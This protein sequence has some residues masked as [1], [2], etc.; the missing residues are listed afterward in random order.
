MNE[1]WKNFFKTLGPGIL[2]A[3]TCVGVSHLVQSTRAGADYGFALVWVIV[4]A[5]IF[6]YPFFEFT[7]RYTSATGKSVLDGYYGMGKWILIAFGISTLFTMFIVTTAVTFVTAGLLSNLIPVFGFTTDIWV[8]I[9]LIISGMI[10]LVGKFSILDLLLKVIGTVLVI[11]TLAAFGSAYW[12]VEVTPA[13]DFVP[14]DPYDTVGILFIVALMGWMPTAVDMSVWT[15]LWTEARI[16]Q[17]NYHPKLKESLLDFNLGYIISAV[18]ALFFMGLGALVIFGTNTELS[19]SSPVFASQLINMYTNSIGSWSYLIIAVAAFS[20]MFSTSIT[21]MDGYG[22]TMA[23]ITKLLGNHGADDSRKAFLFWIIVLMIGTYIV[24]TQ[25]VNSLKTLVDLATGVSFIIAPFAGYL[26]YRV[27]YRPE[28]PD[29][30]RPPTWLKWLAI[31]GLLFLL[32]FSFI[33]IY[34]K[35]IS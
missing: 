33:Y 6:K 16:K 10:L 17:T 29:S 22:R 32:L 35:Q 15:S 1:K 28:I 25:F 5:I 34:L 8:L 3:S 20:T 14:K 23:R 12:G 26:N 4:L 24:S 2:F 11:S 9:I 31:L 19:N 7:S 27:I 18:L 21:V 30:H 13:A